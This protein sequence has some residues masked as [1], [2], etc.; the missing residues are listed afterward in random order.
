[1]K[2]EPYVRYTMP[3]ILREKIFQRI[4]NELPWEQSNT[5]QR[6]NSMHSRVSKLVQ[7]LSKSDVKK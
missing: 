7:T 2:G 3:M 5:I 4:Y 6:V 1:M